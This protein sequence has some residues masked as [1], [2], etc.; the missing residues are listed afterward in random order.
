M[1]GKFKNGSTENASS[2]IHTSFGIVRKKKKSDSI[3]IIKNYPWIGSRFWRG[4]F[5]RDC[6]KM[7][8]GRWKRRKWNGDNQRGE[9]D[10]GIQ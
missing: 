5:G 1:D 8:A 4:G 6:W 10:T 7:T 2:T 9:K 3:E